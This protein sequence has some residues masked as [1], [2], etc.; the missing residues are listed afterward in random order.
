MFDLNVYLSSKGRIGRQ[1]WWLATIVL[2]V[3][4]F[5]LV[6]LFS[7]LL[8]NDD[9]GFSVILVLIVELLFAA[10]YITVSVKRLHDL[11]K[12]GWYYLI[13]LI[14]FIGGLILFIQLGFI[15]GTI[16]SNTYGDDPLRTAVTNT[17][18]SIPISPVSVSPVPATPVKAPAQQCE[19][20]FDEAGK[21]LSVEAP[22]GQ[23]MLKQNGQNK[24][25][26]QRANSLLQATEILKKLSYIPQLTYYV[27]D[28]PDGTLGR[29][30]NGYYTDSPVKTKNLAVDFRRGKSEAVEFLGLHDFG[31]VLKNQTTAAFLKQNGQYSRLVLLMK[32]GECGYES[33]VETQAG[34]FDRECY[35]CGTKNEGT[36]SSINVFL[37]S[38]MVEI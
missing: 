17:I 25:Y 34:A 26:S 38:G 13:A 2:Y 36:R 5:V 19:V 27:V 7:A 15:Q 23:W 22:Q 14:P 35:C 37:G 18:S 21:V 4:L 12:S 30:I 29:D 10:A 11:D 9:S 33:P 16:G 6:F 32:C 20:K 3:I 24:Y 1:T 31:D 8:S 28:T